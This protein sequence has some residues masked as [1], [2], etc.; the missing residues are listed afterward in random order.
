MLRSGQTRWHKNQQLL[1]NCGF[2]KEMCDWRALYDHNNCKYRHRFGRLRNHFLYTYF[3]SSYLIFSYLILS[4]LVLSQLV[5]SFLIIIILSQSFYLIL[6]CFILSYLIFSY[7]LL[8]YLIYRPTIF[9][10]IDECDV[11]GTSFIMMLLQ[12]HASI[13]YFV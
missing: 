9:L 4:Y 5:L 1:S 2:Q 12:P 13:T 3:I 10:A 7:L 6:T 11:L 8:C